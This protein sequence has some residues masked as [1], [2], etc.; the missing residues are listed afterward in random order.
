MSLTHLWQKTSMT[1]KGYHNLHVL[2]VVQLIAWVSPLFAIV[3]S[4]FFSLPMFLVGMLVITAVGSSAG[5]H[6]YF[7]HKSFETG[8]IRHWILALITTLTTQGSIA[9]WVV[10]H[11][12]HHV[13]ADTEDDPISPT[14]VGFFR[15]FFAIQDMSSYKDISPKR[16]VR[17]LQ[18]PAVRFFHNWYWPTI[19]L[20]VVLLGLIDLTLILNLYLLPV[21]MVRFIF[22]IQNTFGHGIPRIGSYKNYPTK[23][24]SVNTPLVNM[25]TFFMGE[26]LHNNHH[27]NPGRYDYRDKWYELDLTGLIIKTVF[28]K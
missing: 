5:L 4:E 10:Y 27:A 2:K 22:G 28:A 1:V 23:D 14:F 3:F 15:S 18:D 24:Q 19:A 20:Y 16:I 12:A 9:M 8:P 11:R 6:R 26:T 13:Y 25:L 7:G 17:E 21:F